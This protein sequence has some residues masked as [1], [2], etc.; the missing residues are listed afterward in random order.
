VDK[1]GVARVVESSG[2]FFHQVFGNF[3]HMTTTAGGISSIVIFASMVCAPFA[4]HLVDRIG[5]RAT[6]M[7]IGSLLLIPSH[8]AMGLTHLYP[9]VPMA[10]LGV[11]FVLIPA[12][13]W[14]SIP[15]LVRKQAV[16]TAFG[17]MTMIQNIGLALFPAL[18]GRLRD[19]THTY[20][21]SQVMFAALGALGLAFAL[22]LKRTDRTLGDVLEKP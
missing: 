21:A 15:L 16:G 6:L 14:P 11:A 13:M 4:G 18:N 7:V 2:G 20:T 12:A 5:R 9:V 1:W 17:L 8:L 22:L 19:I 10:T 3:L